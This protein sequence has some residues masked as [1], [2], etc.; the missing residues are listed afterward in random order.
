[1]VP[2]LKGKKSSKLAQGMINGKFK[3]DRLTVWNFD[4]FCANQILC[5]IIFSKKKKGQKL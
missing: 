2:F 4:N 5:E 1:M 3:I